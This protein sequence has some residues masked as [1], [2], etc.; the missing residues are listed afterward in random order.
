MKIV[1]LQ[2]DFPPQSFGGAGISTHELAVEMKNAGHEVFVITTCR[3]ESEAGELDYH[4]LK[5]FK[6]VSDYHQRWRAYVSL[7]NPLVVRQ[8]KQI[9][10]EVK[11]DVVHANNIHGYLSYYSLKVAK[12]YAKGVVFTARDAM[13]FNYAKLNTER[14]LKNLDPRTTWRD[15]LRQAG[16]R[17]NPL[18]NL[19][20]R[21]YLRYA[22]RVF[23]ISKSLQEALTQNGFSNVEMIHNGIDVHGWDIDSATITRFRRQYNL[24]DKRVILFGGRL[25][26]AKGGAKAVE[27][28]AQIVKEV[29]DTVLL[30]VGTVDEYAKVMKIRAKKLG[31]ENHLIF[32]GWVEREEIKVA[33]A[34]SYVV[35]MP[36]IYLDTFGRVN[37]EAMASKKPVV[38]TCY[39]GTPEIVVD[40][41]T[42]YIVNP[43][44]PEEI[45]EKSIDLLKNPAKAKEYG[46][47]GYKRAREY[48]N[49]KNVAEQYIAVYNT[50]I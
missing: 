44:H 37:I 7:Y 14:Y 21:H 17:W 10:K 5:V 45:A 3:K 49:L 47:A 48:F 31:I 9:L 43:L 13:A 15:H 16:R 24:L 46:E 12:Q 2:D 38:G 11:P 40:G 34:V 1:F 26:E 4:G 25:S 42:G 41:V 50:I 32:T 35:L 20:I 6:I 33:Y 27:A 29:P 8:V 19:L 23:A 22:D 18:R 39:G 28:L 36:S 30:I